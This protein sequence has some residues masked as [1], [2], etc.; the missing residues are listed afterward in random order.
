[1][2]LHKALKVRIYPT[3]AQ[4]L[5]IA[6]TIGCCRK[7]Y[8]ETLARRNAFYKENISNKEKELGQKMTKEQK[9]KI[10]KQFNVTAKIL[11]EDFEFMKEVSS[12]SETRSILDLDTAFKKFFKHEAGFPRK[13][14][15][16]RK[17]SFYNKG[18]LGGGIK[19]NPD[20]KK[21]FV[22]KLGWIKFR[23]SKYPEWFTGGNPVLKSIT[24]S[25][26]PSGKYYASVSFQ[27]NVP[28][29]QKEFTNPE[30]TIGL[31]FSPADM[32]FDSEGRSAKT[33]FGYVAQKQRMQRRMTMLQRRLK[34]KKR[35]SRA[36]LKA[37]TAIAKLHEKIAARR[38][39][40]QNKET[41][42]L[43]DNYQVIGVEDLN[44]KGLMRA[45]RNAKNYGD[46]GWGRFV[47]KLEQ[48]SIERNCRVVKIGRF[49]PSSKLCHHCGTKND[50]LKLSDRKWFCPNCGELLPR[51]V[52][53]AQN[54]KAEAVRMVESGE[55]K[56]VKPKPSK[57][58]FKKKSQPETDG[59]N[60]VPVSDGEVKPVESTNECQATPAGVYGSEFDE[61]GTRLST[62]DR[63]NIL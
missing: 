5:M 45:S 33:D 60:N 22:V 3:E 6:K 41:R 20:L 9:S 61:T 10:L 31:D 59:V 8:N 25:R 42:R 15:R 63:C 43:V 37:K 35:G 62:S 13:H 12:D 54:I 19:F 50:E 17:E 51:D 32:Y 48:K 38:D 56:D 28:D 24:T 7:A 44:L 2:E 52:N 11:R 18:A 55:Y 27:L 36:Y 49:F 1:M 39:D 4:K 47:T 14:K 40:W 57:N 58:R 34:R 16:G 29:F 21:L 53:A 30:K 23:C 46:A 26:T